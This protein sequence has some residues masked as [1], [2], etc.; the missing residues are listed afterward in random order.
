M[1]SFVKKTRTMDVLLLVIGYVPLFV[2][3]SLLVLKA[4]RKGEENSA[5]LPE[6]RRELILE[7]D[8]SSSREFEMEDLRDRLCDLMERERLYLNPNIR[9]NDVAER[10]LTNKSYLA[11][12]IRVK[13]NKN[14]C[15]LV[16][17]Y[18][19]KEAMRLYAKNP[20]ENIAELS[21]KVGFNSMTTFT[22]AFSR[23]TGFTPADWCRQ[24][25]RKNSEKRSREQ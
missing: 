11:Q 24:F 20:E 3:I 13:F 6:K 1:Y 17:Y 21:R 18:R 2:V 25:K 12:T 9:V 19:V 22:S 7:D 15:Q 16:H 4:R 10:L 23:N 14:F 8:A 5:V